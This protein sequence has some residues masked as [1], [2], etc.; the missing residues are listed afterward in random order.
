MLA[1]ARNCCGRLLISKRDHSKRLTHTIGVGDPAGIHY[2]YDLESGNIACVWRGDFV[3]ATPC[4]MSAAMARSVRRAPCN[5][6][7]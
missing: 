4:G 7:L 3:D 6:Y 2:V 1:Q 5:I